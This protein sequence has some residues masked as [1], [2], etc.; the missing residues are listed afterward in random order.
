MDI[1]FENFQVAGFITHPIRWFFRASVD[2]KVLMGKRAL[3]LQR[4][5]LLRYALYAALLY[6][7]IEMQFNNC[8][9]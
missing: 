5:R 7:T 4:S 6:Q 3:W 1:L 9:K 2:P 8:C